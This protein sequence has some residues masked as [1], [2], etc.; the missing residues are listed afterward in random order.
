MERAPPAPTVGGMN[1]LPDS[2]TTYP[3]QGPGTRVLIAGGGVAALEGM[4]A[5]RALADERLTIE[6]LAPEAEFVY[7]PLSVA[8]PFGLGEPLQL[9]LEKMVR[10]A[11]AR[12]HRGA[13]AA[14]DPVRQVARTAAGEE[15][16]YDFLLIGVGGGRR[17]PLPGALAFGGERDIGRFRALLAEI[18]AGAVSEVAFALAGGRSWSLPLYELALMTGRFRAERGIRDVRLTL[19]TPEQ[20]PLGVFGPRAAEAVE[21]RLSHA[22]V[23]LRTGAYACRCDPGTLCLVPEAELRADRVVTLATPAPPS[24]AGLPSDADGFLATDAHCRVDGLPGVYAAGDVTSFPLKQ[25][26]IAAQQADAAAEHIASTA[27][28]LVTPRPF[29]AVLRGM[30]LTGDRPA[31]LRSEVTGGRG[32]PDVVDI[33]PLWWPPAKIV[34]RYLGPFLA[35]QADL[36]DPAD[37][38]DPEGLLVSWEADRGLGDWHELDPQQAEVRA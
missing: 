30:L 15:L 9:D 8:A 36:P 2:R 5:L 28:A 35:E 32:G 24:I 19:V 18:E 37:I 38:D 31:Y 29:R 16:P 1:D 34:A 27:G 7:R 22:G 33:E 6:L 4:L 23:A 11:G 17:N 20:R 26:G 25:G 13:L 14:V 21:R 12:L 10:R 3:T